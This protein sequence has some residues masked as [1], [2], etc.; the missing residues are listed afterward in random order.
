MRGNPKLSNLAEQIQAAETEYEEPVENDEGDV[1]QEDI[2]AYNEL[3]RAGFSNPFSEG[4]QE[5]P[6]RPEDFEE[7]EQE[8]AS[9]YLT[10]QE[11]ALLLSDHGR[12]LLK[13][14]HFKRIKAQQAITGGGEG[15]L[16]GDDSD[17]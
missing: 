12:A 11:K 1:S 9:E 15:F 6:L 10:Q 8:G 7:P 2:D 16:D 17:N 14:D 3:K 4:V 13:A 5:R